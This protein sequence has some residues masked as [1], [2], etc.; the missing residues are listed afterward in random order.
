MLLSLLLSFAVVQGGP[1]DFAAVPRTLG[2]LP[3]LVSDAPLYGLFLFGPRGQT[4]VWAVLD[5]SDPE[6]R[7][8]DTLYLD[9]DGD[10]DLR[11]AGE[12]F[13]GEPAALDSPNPRC[14]FLIEEFRPPGSE[15]VHRDFKITWTAKRVSYRMKWR[16]DEVTMGGYGPDPDSYGSF[17]D[18]LGTA[19]ILVPGHDRPFQFQ[20][21][22]SQLLH[23]GRDN[24][25]KV[26]VGNPGSGLGCFSTVDD[27]FLPPEEFLLATLLYT[28]R[29]GKQQRYQTKLTER[30]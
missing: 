14:E 16:G 4:R 6:A 1:I 19:P 27:R 3:D 21:W 18:S 11:E 15:A 29:Q 30:C 13:A 23:R 9:L 2:E 20:P 25:F 28:D 10:G 24:D 5:R 12:R 8:Y 7:V 17:G 26:F 22:M